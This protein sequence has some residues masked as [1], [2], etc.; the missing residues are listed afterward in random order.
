M[1]VKQRAGHLSYEEDPKVR[2]SCKGVT[3]KDVMS[4]KSI[5]EAGGMVYV[6]QRAGHLSY[7]EDPKV[8]ISWGRGSQTKMRK[9]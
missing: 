3:D 4:L 9:V 6:K 2:I 8:R 1:Y 5:F 7:E